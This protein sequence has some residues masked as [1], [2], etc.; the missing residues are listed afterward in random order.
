MKTR[1]LMTACATALLAFTSIAAVAQDRGDQNRGQSKKQYRQFNEKQQKAARDYYN[2]HRD[3]PVFRQPDQWNDDYERRIQ[4]GY[5]LDADMRRM[6]RPAPDDMTR[7]LG[8]PPRGYR[9]IVIGGHVILVDSG[10][11]VH[12]AIHLHISL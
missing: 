9:Y 1:W 12:D 5:V 6:S 2:Q 7:G 11:R 3:H 8:R 10:Y 4:P